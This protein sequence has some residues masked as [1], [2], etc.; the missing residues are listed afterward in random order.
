M[1]PVC[2]GAIAARTAKGNRLSQPEAASPRVALGIM[3]KPPR[4]GHSKTR[5]AA[6][7]GA[8]AASDLAAAFLADTGVTVARLVREHCTAAFAFYAPDAPALEIA[9]QTLAQ[10]SSAYPNAAVADLLPG[11]PLI[12]QRGDDLGQRMRHA[13]ADMLAIR[14]DTAHE[15]TAVARNSD[16]ESD[17]RRFAGAMVIG[18]D[19]PTLPLD[20]LR[21]AVDALL[22][23][24]DRLVIGPAHDGGYYLIGLNLLHPELFDG[25][26][27]STSSVLRDTLHIARSLALPVIELPPWRDID[28]LSD[29]EALRDE[30]ASSAAG[31]VGAE[32]TAPHTRAALS[33]LEW[34]SAP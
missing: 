13:L 32:A 34:R 11:M 9:Q 6:S 31:G 12:A 23:G 20:Y 25:I 26:A 16:L 21:Q 18:A 1:L 14:D 2:K 30:L 17:A 15:P 22:A 5:L 8:S 4:A 29:L 33:R 24:G 3:C 7:I 28:N 19:C 10:P 27:W